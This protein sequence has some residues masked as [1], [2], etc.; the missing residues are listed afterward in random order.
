MLCARGI[1][2]VGSVGRSVRLVCESGFG[3]GVGGSLLYEIRLFFI[4][5]CL[6]ILFGGA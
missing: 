1:G 2:G 5:G 3:F 4:V 6:S